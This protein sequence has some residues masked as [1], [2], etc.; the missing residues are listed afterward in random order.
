MGYIWKNYGIY[1]QHYW[2]LFSKNRG[3]IWKQL[4]D[5]WSNTIDNF[6]GCI[7]KKLWDIFGKT[8]GYTRPLNILSKK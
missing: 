5:N 8:M 6:M 4:W 1:L 2:D 7:R 3:Y